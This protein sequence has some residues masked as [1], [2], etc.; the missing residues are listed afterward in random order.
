MRES[1]LDFLE[2]PCDFPL[3]VVGKTSDQ[4]E[5][6]VLE[7]MRQHIEETCAISVSQNPSKKNN[8]ISLTVNFK[9]QS[10]QQLEA[11]YHCLHDCPDVVMTL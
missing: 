7:L 6:I 2:Y 9:A 1:S 11:I 8:Y 10:R 4:F 3:K 5:S